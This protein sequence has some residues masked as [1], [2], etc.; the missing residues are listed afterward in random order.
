MKEIDLSLYFE[1]CP[2]MEAGDFYRDASQRLGRKVEMY[3]VPEHFPSV[4][5]AS[6]VLLGLDESRGGCPG[7]GVSLPDKRHCN[8]ADA[9]RRELYN[10]YAPQGLGKVVDLGNMRCGKRVEDTYFALTEVVGCLLNQKSALIL[11]GG[12]Q[13]LTYAVYQA[14]ARMQKMA[15]IV[16][17]DA[18]LDLAEGLGAD[19]NPLDSPISHTNYMGKMAVEPAN[20]LFN[21]MN[22]GYQTYLVE[23]EAVSLMDKLYFDACRYGRLQDDIQDAEPYLRDAD[24]VSFD[25]S[26]LKRQESPANPWAMPTGFDAGQ[27]CQMARYAGL[28]RETNVLGFFEYYPFYERDSLSAQLQAEMVWCFLDGMRFR[29][30][31]HPLSAT[32]MDFKQYIVPFEDPE[33]DI[34]F[35]KCR[36][37][38]RWWMELPCSEEQRNRYGRHCYLA[39]SYHDYE[40][41]TAGNFPARWWNAVQRIK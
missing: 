5:G 23:Q 9:V 30:D 39:C 34:V 19:E 24:V 12:T 2:F 25:L 3:T 18:R 40:T 27:F 7:E 41:A 16:T 28:S 22:V 31:D 36:Q 8:G 14:Y 10:L 17:V 29:C 4:E 21:Y 26:A 1:P 33:T 35:Y 38:D 15:N 6:V 13:D 11:L 37:T 20:Y 32:G